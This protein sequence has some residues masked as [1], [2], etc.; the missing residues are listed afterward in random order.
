AVHPLVGEAGLHAAFEV[1]EVGAGPRSRWLDPGR[2][3]P[4][5]VIDR[6]D[7]GVGAD[8]TPVREKVFEEWTAR[9]EPRLDPAG[10]GREHP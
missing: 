5:G 7:L 10:L 6:P 4:V 3:E 2:G 9:I 1:G 8:G